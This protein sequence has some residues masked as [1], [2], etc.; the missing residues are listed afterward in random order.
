VERA[1]SQC[2]PNIR[3]F[4]GKDHSADNTVKALLTFCAPIIRKM[5]T[6]SFIAP[7]TAITAPK[8]INSETETYRNFRLAFGEMQ[9]YSN[10]KL[11]N[12]F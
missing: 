3:S 6:S 1:V 7:N 4:E 8:P 10:L 11:K 5:E 9:K 2:C 12:K